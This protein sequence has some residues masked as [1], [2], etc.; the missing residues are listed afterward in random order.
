MDPSWIPATR[1][2]AVKIVA[3]LLP[4]LPP[5]EEYRLILMQRDR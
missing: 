1:G 3:Q 4:Y 5:G 2:K